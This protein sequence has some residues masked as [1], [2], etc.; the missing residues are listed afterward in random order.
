MEGWCAVRQV[1][2]KTVMRCTCTVYQVSCFVLYTWIRTQLVE[3]SPR[4]RSVV[5]SNPTQGSFF[6]EKRES[7]S[8]CIY[9]PCFDLSC[10]PLS[11]DL[12]VFGG[13]II[14]AFSFR[15]SLS[16]PVYQVSCFVLYTWIRTQPAE[17]PW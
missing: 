16:S 11:L 7:C 4:T 14:P 3:R 10:M 12:G 9:L 17:L 8:G 15:L 6:F 2:A 1:P 13:L 5:G